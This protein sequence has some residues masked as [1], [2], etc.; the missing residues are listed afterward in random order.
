MNEAQL[1]RFLHALAR[2]SDQPVR[3]IITGAAAAAVWGAARPSLD[4]DF[5]I[6]PVGRRKEWA[7][8]EA[9]IA[10][11]VQR[12]GIPAN[13]A[14]DI[15][16]WGPVSLLDYQRHTVAYRRFGQLRVELLDPAY[17]TIGK[18]SR[19]LDPDVRDL[20]S[21]LKRRHLAPD[22][23]IR[24][25]ARALRASPRSDGLAQFRRQAEHFLRTYG[26]SVWG[27][28]FNPDDAVSRF[29]RLI[30]TH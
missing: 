23:L 18:I 9:A 26:R 14:Q 15:D 4:V 30:Q 29:N 19:Y 8:I 11:A 22:R 10:R 1:Q 28:R 6:I 3:L 17:W 5:A 12:T 2:E 21:V 27:A 25:W 16:R 7:L 13:F 20:V 24:L